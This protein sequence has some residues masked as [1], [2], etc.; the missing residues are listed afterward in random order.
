MAQLRNPSYETTPL[1]SNGT[2]MERRERDVETYS[3]NKSHVSVGVTALTDST[4]GERMAYND[5]TT[6]DW[7]HELVRQFSHL[8]A[9]N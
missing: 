4:V 1:L 8:R 9:Y 3:L 7:M 6:I 2:P 5:Y